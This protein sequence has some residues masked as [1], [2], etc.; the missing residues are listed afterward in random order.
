MSRFTLGMHKL[1]ELEY[2][3]QKEGLARD[4]Q[5]DSEARDAF[6]KLIDLGVKRA[7]LNGGEVTYTRRNYDKSSV[8]TFHHRLVA[9]W[10]ASSYESV[11][12]DEDSD[13]LRWKLENEL[14]ERLE[15]L[16]EKRDEKRR[17]REEEDGSSSSQ[18]TD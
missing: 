10:D 15:R 7:M 12:G 6:E 1:H 3:K 2:K 4:S 16:R 11:S 9:P 17:E 8:L 13:E 18:S 14:E 5:R